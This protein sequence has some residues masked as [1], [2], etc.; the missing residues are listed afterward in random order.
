MAS[1]FLPCDRFNPVRSWSA[2]AAMLFLACSQTPPVSN[3]A[4]T[5]TTSSAGS[6]RLPISIHDAQGHQQGAFL[7]FP[8]GKVSIDG[9]GAG[10]AY[11][12][13][14][15]SRW[16]PV[17]RNS[18]SPDGSHYA[19][20]GATDINKPILHIVDVAS[21][22]DRTF[23]LPAELFS[24]IGGIDI[25]EYTNDVVYMGLLGE[26]SNQGLW[27]FNLATGATHLVA[28]LS[29]VGAVDSQVVWLGTFNAADPH[30]WNFFPAQRSNQIERLD[31]TDGTRVPWLYRPG[32]L[33][34][35]VGFDSGHHPIVLSLIDKD[36]LEL[37]ALLDAN[38]E[39]SIYKG[40]ASSWAG[41]IDS[42]DG[43]IVGD[44]HGVWIGTN[45]GIYLYSDAG[46]LQKVSNQP[47]YP[48]NTCF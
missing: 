41:Y 5:P 45:M 40:S 33:V 9:G 47:G 16:L 12:D 27:A 21:G 11:F 28:N 44:S 22:A 24:G 35:V 2:L 13:R 18:V 20:G 48:A 43:A 19:F 23:D 14:Q 36:T 7:S 26:A 29:A 37:T 8:A 30:P 31:L 39:R 46:G 4:A 3:P 17:R 15:L 25:F 38:T 1:P 6:C 10:G 32:N 34:G 42:G